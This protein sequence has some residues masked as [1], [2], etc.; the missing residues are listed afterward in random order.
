MKNKL[1]TAVVLNLFLSWSLAL[2]TYLMGI[3]FAGN[4]AA[5]VGIIYM[6]MP[7]LSLVILSKFFWHIPLKQWGI[8]KPQNRWV[9]AACLFPIALSLLTFVLSFLVPGVRFEPGMDG[10]ITRFAGNANPETLAAMKEQIASLGPYLPLIILAQSLVGG[11]TINSF[12]AFGEEYFWRGFL[13]QQLEKVSWFKSSL[14]IGSIWGLWHAPL[15]LQGHNYPQHPIAGVFM[16]ILW[17]I[18][19]S[20]SMVYFVRKTKSVFTAALFH[21]LLNG[22]AGLPLIWTSNGNDL[23][24]GVTGLVGCLALL[25]L[26]LFLYFYDHQNQR[27]SA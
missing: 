20:Y 16:M 26:N 14:I 19:L 8:R 23:V 4:N 13:L 1:I 3:K 27:I 18:L 25:V 7:T 11:L 9:L 21:G 10:I 5:I 17:C 15:I 24:V 22:T 6:F 2:A 12:V